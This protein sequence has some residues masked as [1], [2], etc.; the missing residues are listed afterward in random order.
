M[1]NFFFAACKYVLA[2]IISKLGKVRINTNFDRLFIISYNKYLSLKTINESYS[3]I[4]TPAVVPNKTN[5]E[6]AFCRIFAMSTSHPKCSTF[7]KS[8]TKLFFFN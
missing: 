2:V 7:P 5:I 6:I 1:N 4:A 8:A 3:R